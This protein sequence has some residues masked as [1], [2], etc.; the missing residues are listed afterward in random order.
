MGKEQKTHK[1]QGSPKQPPYNE[2]TIR[3]RAFA[4]NGEPVS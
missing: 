2:I 3:I 4:H 1:Q